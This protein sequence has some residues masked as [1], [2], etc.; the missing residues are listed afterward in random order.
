MRI[1]AQCKFWMEALYSSVCHG[2][3]L[4]MA[5]GPN[6]ELH[7]FVGRTEGTIVRPRS[8]QLD[9]FGWDP[10]FL[11]EGFEQ[12]FAEMG[13]EQKNTISH[14]YRNEQMAMQKKFVCDCCSL[15]Q[16][17]NKVSWCLR[18]LPL[19]CLCSMQIS[20]THSATDV[21]TGACKRG[22]ARVALMLRKWHANV[23]GLKVSEEIRSFERADRSVADHSSE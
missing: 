8:C 19:A 13:K 20:G 15:Q 22:V 17:R 3:R 10:I 18:L 9:T 16:Q 14:R 11:P 1:F 2:M 7:L 23:K 21:P 6:E 4:S 12:T 5:T